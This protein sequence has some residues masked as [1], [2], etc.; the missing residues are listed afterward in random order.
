M[1]KKDWE[2]LNHDIYTK[3]FR[4]SAFERA[5]Y[6]RISRNIGYVNE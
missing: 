1:K 3:M 4:Q 5:G 6:E 2:T